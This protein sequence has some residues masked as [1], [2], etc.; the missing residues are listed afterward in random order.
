MPGRVKLNT[1]NTAAQKAASPLPDPIAQ[2]EDGATP[3]PLTVSDSEI[4]VHAYGLG[5]QF[6]S[7]GGGRRVR[8]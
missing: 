4:A 5:G 8:V 6:K 1:K 3:E 2:I 7:I